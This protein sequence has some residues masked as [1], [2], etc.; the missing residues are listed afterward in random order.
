ML[1]AFV[2]NIPSSF[3]IPFHV[4]VIT[5]A[6]LIDKLEQSDPPD[7]I[8]E[9]L[10]EEISREPAC[11]IRNYRGKGV[12]LIK[13]VL[14][15]V[16]SQDRVTGTPRW[17]RMTDAGHSELGPADRLSR[18]LWCIGHSLQ[19]CARCRTCTYGPRRPAR[20]QNRVWD[21]VKAPRSLR[22]STLPQSVSEWLFAR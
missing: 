22:R 7:E 4:T 13:G 14:P 16:T 9:K 12:A 20:Q 8:T 19:G 1:R 6:F 5:N 2:W 18:D 15:V 11:M 17:L 3:N 10:R 21:F